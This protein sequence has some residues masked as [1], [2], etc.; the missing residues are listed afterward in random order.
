MAFYLSTKINRF[1]K[2]TLERGFQTSTSEVSDIIYSVGN[3][4]D[5]KMI[6]DKLKRSIPTT[7]VRK[8]TEEELEALA[9]HRQYTINTGF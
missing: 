9:E 6:S 5:S 4:F 2:K 3:I 8:L 1:L 7:G